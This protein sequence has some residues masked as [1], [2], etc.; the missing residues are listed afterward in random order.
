MDEPKTFSEDYVKELRTEAA[1]YRTQLKELK[2]EVENYKALETQLTQI[3]VE[4]EL[5]RRGVNVDPSFVKFAEGMKPADAVDKFLESYPQF[6]PQTNPNENHLQPQPKDIPNAIPPSPGQVNVP[7]PKA[8]GALFG[9]PLDEI[10]ND[11]VARRNVRSLYRS[12]L[13]N[14]IDE[15]Y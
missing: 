6:L 12:L 7:G 3:R 15:E 4:N 14:G 8:R 1:G 2:S 11:P 13:P 10:E 9:R 5:V